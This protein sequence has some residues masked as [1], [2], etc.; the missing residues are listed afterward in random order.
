MTQFWQFID[1]PRQKAITLPTNQ[2]SNSI[3]D[4]EWMGIRKGGQ[5]WSAIETGWAFSR[6]EPT[7][8]SGQPIV[9]NTMDTPSIPGNFQPFGLTNN[10]RYFIVSSRDSTGAQPDQLNFYEPNGTLVREA[11]CSDT[12]DRDNSR[13]TY[14]NHDYYV[15]SQVGG[16]FPWEIKV[17][18]HQAQLLRKFPVL[19]ITGSLD[20]INGITTDGKYL[21]LLV[22]RITN[23]AFDRIIK[24]DVR[25]EE[26]GTGY[27]PGD[28]LSF[29]NGIT[30]NGIYL[31]ARVTDGDLTLEPA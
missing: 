28:G 12:P 22:R 27:T 31:I 14:L 23:T 4:I 6:W 24:L 1:I 17:Y 13:L 7:T 5:T 20:R 18:D 11:P 16:D 8:S 10:K 26:I 9:R 30:F 21:Y 15:V 29:L 25:G 19:S 2:P 3:R